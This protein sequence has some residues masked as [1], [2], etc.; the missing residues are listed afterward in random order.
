MALQRV[1][2]ANLGKA[3]Q[4]NVD[5][6]AELMTDEHRPNLRLG[7]YVDGG[8]QMVNHSAGEYARGSVSTNRVEGYFAILKRGI[9]G[10]FHHVSRR[11]LPRYLAEFDSRY[12]ARHLSDSERAVGVIRGAVGKRL[13]YRP[14]IDPS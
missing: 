6:S 14:L 8:H 13:T 3:L 2:T 9:Y 10:T 12:S 7:A 1:T 4:D 5:R 11:H